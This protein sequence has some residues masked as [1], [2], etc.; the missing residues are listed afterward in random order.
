MISV[1]SSSSVTPCSGGGGRIHAF[2]FS[3]LGGLCRTLRQ[4]CLGLV[5]LA[6][7]ETRPVVCGQ[8][9]DAVGNTQIELS[10]KNQTPAWSHLFKVC[11]TSYCFLTFK[12]NKIRD[13]TT[14]TSYGKSPL[15]V[16][17]TVL[18]IIQK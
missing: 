3:E 18:R 4:V 11:F 6:Y 1:V 14:F 8:Y 17:Y 9:K 10:G 13:H 15:N 16:E 2:E 5:E 12:T 7:P